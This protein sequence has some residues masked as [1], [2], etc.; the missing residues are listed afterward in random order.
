MH[1]Q[2]VSPPAKFGFM[3]PTYD[4]KLPQVL[5]WDSS[6]PSFFTKL[7]KGVADLD[8]VTHGSH[9]KLGEALETTY[10]AI[11]PR[12]LGALESDGRSIKPCLIHGDLWEGNVGTDVDSKDI[13]IFDAC[14]YYA[15]NEMEFA[16]WRCTHRGMHNRGYEEEYY[17]HHINKSEPKDE[18]DDRIR[19]Y[20][21]KTKL[22]YSAHEL[23]P[24]RIEV[25]MQ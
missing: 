6:W 9:G 4:G 18:W 3:V 19:L 14:S 8:I 1:K 5:D 23:G 17:R 21:V 25:R 11:I 2:S 13:Y 10:Q 20:S 15:H 16:I 12:L 24:K 7:L 22:M